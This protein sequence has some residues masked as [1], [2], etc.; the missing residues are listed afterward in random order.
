MDMPQFVD[1][2][3]LLG[4]D[5]TKTIRG[6][7]PKKAFELIQKHKTIEGVLQNIDTE[8]YPVPDNWQYEEARRLFLKPEVDSCENIN[9]QWG[10]PDVEE[11]VKFLCGEKN[12]NEERIRT[13]LQKMEKGRQSGQQGRIDSFFAVTSTVKSEPTAAKRKATE[14]KSKPK[15]TKKRG[16]NIAKKLKK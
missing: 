14:E 12:F 11:I 5:Y 15:E 13:S 10:K 6:V 9:F 2:C 16:S 7:G 4:C 1:L 3:I 8:K